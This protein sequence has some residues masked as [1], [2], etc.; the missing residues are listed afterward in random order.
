MGGASIEDNTMGSNRM[1]IAICV[2]SEVI[3]I[4]GEVKERMGVSGARV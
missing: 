3:R 2:Y 1:S 4:G